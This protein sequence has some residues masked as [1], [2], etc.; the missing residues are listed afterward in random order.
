MKTRNCKASDNLFQGY[1]II[2]AQHNLFVNTFML[3]TRFWA[4]IRGVKHGWM[5]AK[6]PPYGGLFEKF[7][8]SEIGVGRR[9][10]D[11]IDEF[12]TFRDD[13]FADFFAGDELLDVPFGEGEFLELISVS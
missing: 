10:D 12:G 7:A 5:V 6:R 1:T 8:P 3:K 4:S 9:L 13:D 11:D 2:V